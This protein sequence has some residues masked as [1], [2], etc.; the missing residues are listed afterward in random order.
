MYFSIFINFSST[1]SRPYIGPLII[2]LY[3]DLFPTLPRAYT[4]LLPVSS[5]LLWSLVGSV[6]PLFRLLALHSCKRCPRIII[7]TFNHTNE[8]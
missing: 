8:K 6:L 1:D 4:S 2:L 5:P 3:R 7:I